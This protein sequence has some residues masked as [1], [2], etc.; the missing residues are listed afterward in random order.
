MPLS[1]LSLT[2]RA[3]SPLL[4]LV[5]WGALPGPARAMEFPAGSLIIPMDVQYQNLGM[6]QAYGLV[7][8]LI[9]HGIP[10]YW[11]IESDKTFRDR[12]DPG[13][14][15]PWDCSDPLEGGP[16]QFLTLSPD[17]WTAATVVY[18]DTGLRAAGDPVPLHGYRGAPFVIHADDAA[19]ARGVIDAWNDPA[20]WPVAPWAE[21]PVFSVVSVHEAPQAF[22]APLPSPY[23]VL[24]HAPRPAIVADGREAEF[25]AVLRAAGIPQSDGTAFSEEPCAPGACG[26]GTSRTDFLTLEALSPQ[27]GYCLD[28]PSFGALTTLVDGEGIAR[29]SQVALA[30]FTVARRESVTCEDGPCVQAE[31]ECFAS[32]LAFHGHRALTH[33]GQFREGG[34]W[35]FALGEAVYALENASRRSGW[36]FFDSVLPGHFFV[37]LPAP[38]TCPCL[39]PEYTCYED[40]C[41]NDWNHTRFDCCLLTDEARRGVVLAS[42]PA[43][44]ARFLEAGLLNRPGWQFDGDLGAPLGPMGLLGLPEPDGTDLLGSST[45]WIASVGEGYLVLGTG[46]TVNYLADVRLGTVL[47]VTSNPE[48]NFSRL[49]LNTLFATNR[50][51]GDAGLEA[52][53]TVTPESGT[54]PDPLLPL[55]TRFGF[56]VTS[57]TRVTANEIRLELDLPDGVNFVSCEPAAQLDERRV[58]WRLDRHEG[59]YGLACT[60]DFPAEGSYP[61]HTALTVDYMGTLGT[62]GSTAGTTTLTVQGTVDTDGDGLPQCH[63]CAE[64]G[65][66]GYA[67]C[68]ILDDPVYPPYDD[69]PPQGDLP[70]VD[71]TD[72]PPPDSCA[73][74]AGA[75]SSHGALSPGLL[76]LLPLA[77]W[78]LARRRR[79]GPMTRVQWRAGRA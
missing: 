35:I 1:R 53:V 51:T 22:E 26:P 48:T 67:D 6:L 9:Q 31:D 18:D 7:Y 79:S 19:V 58:I 14:G 64:Y 17:F 54:C 50:A 34:G 68:G 16:C 24:E 3:L 10:V 46:A 74:T 61:F 70:P 52:E 20:L 69:G 76:W 30:G 63:P 65:W 5:L 66:P 55:Q 44:Q 21:R 45:G 13:D 73:C 62:T 41:Y 33:L 39:N 12:C 49:Y 47:P 77:L 78:R 15:C 38:V 2:R 43:A 56:R 75:R 71:P 60:F 72:P 23:R 28:T 4:A 40:G 29:Y 25:A 57:N 59:R 37:D 32:P 11:I 36:P 8:R 27:R 42:V